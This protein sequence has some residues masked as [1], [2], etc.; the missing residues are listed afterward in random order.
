MDSV[1]LFSRRG[2][3]FHLYTFEC[4][5]YLVELR[6][7][8]ILLFLN[9]Y[10]YI[11]AVQNAYIHH[12]EWYLS[13]THL[14]FLKFLSSPRHPSSSVS[15][16]LR[17]EIWGFINQSD[18]EAKMKTKNDK[19]IS[20]IRHTSLFYSRKVGFYIGIRFIV[21]YGEIQTKLLSGRIRT[22]RVSHEPCF[23]N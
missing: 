9:F 2:N 23:T 3:T 16:G 6:F 13:I 14:D 7:K 22:R 18:D 21:P 19:H 1:F 12:R 8:F 20:R 5:Q 15:H 17:Q 10:S 4:V 11:S